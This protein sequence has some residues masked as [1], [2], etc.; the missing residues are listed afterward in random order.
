MPYYGD[1]QQQPQQ[2]Q[3][4]INLSDYVNSAAPLN[5]P[6]GQRPEEQSQFFGNYNA[7]A[8]QTQSD[9]MDTLALTQQFNGTPL[10]QLYGDSYAPQ[11][12]P[13][14]KALYDKQQAYNAMSEADKQYART[15]GNGYFNNEDMG[16][17]MNLTVGNQS[18]DNQMRTDINQWTRQY[19][20]QIAH[21]ILGQDTNGDTNAKMWASDLL[22]NKA[23]AGNITDSTAVAPGTGDQFKRTLYS[24][25]NHGVLPT[26]RLAEQADARDWWSDH[27]GLN[28][29][30][31]LQQGSGTHEGSG[32]AGQGSGN[33]Q[34]YSMV[35]AGA[36]VG[37][38]GNYDSGHSSYVGN[39]WDG[40]GG[41]Q[42]PKNTGWGTQE[43]YDAGY[44]AP[45]Q[46]PNNSLLA[47][48][49]NTYNGINDTGAKREPPT[50]PARGPGH[51]SWMSPLGQLPQDQAGNTGLGGPTTHP[52]YGPGGYSNYADPHQTGSEATLNG[53]PN[54][55]P[56]YG[57]GGLENARHNSIYGGTPEEGYKAPDLN[58]QWLESMGTPQGTSLQ[59]MLGK[60]VGGVAQG[61]ATA[62][63][64]SS[65]KLYG[66]VSANGSATNPEN[67]A[68]QNTDVFSNERGAT[69]DYAGQ[70]SGEKQNLGTN[71][72]MSGFMTG[73][74]GSSN[75]FDHMDD[76]TKLQYLNIWRKSRGLG[77]VD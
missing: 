71:P 18:I 5:M 59:E 68:N 8:P 56:E 74:T 41:A 66:G 76:A 61:Q 49:P 31:A 33:F 48:N 6:A 72:I 43:G 19:N 26:E 47:Y 2:Q 62:D 54:Y 73:V 3:G 30:Q 65:L 55:T 15:T 60:L 52:T 39:Q 51:G 42:N 77:T 4:G 38:W 21:N 40:M 13:D 45:Y 37:G 9:Y 53:M 50:S 23:W 12:T 1:Y 16:N 70:W 7:Y 35:D 20:D 10:Y 57:G 69:D 34:G 14:I 46:F 27:W 11:M 63:Q 24:Q 22:N 64:P 67:I 17:L 32:M 36:P 58:K 44:H 25:M 28:N 75:P 29:A